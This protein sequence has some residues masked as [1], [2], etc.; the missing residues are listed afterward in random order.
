ML[1]VLGR[2]EDINQLITS[3][4]RLLK[5]TL[6]V[7]EEMLTIEE[8][9]QNVKHY[10]NI[11]NIVHLDE[12]E[13]EI[14]CEDRLKNMMIPKLL[15]QPIIENSILHGFSYGDE[16]KRKRI[17]ITVEENPS[18]QL[19]VTILDNGCG[20]SR[21]ILTNVKKSRRSHIRGI[22][23]KNVEERIH[24]LFGEEYG[25]EVES[26]LHK[27]TRVVVYIPMIDK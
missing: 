2:N 12:L 6:D 24:I 14:Q 22:G 1:S 21:E 8:E 23:L 10:F 13:L 25:V 27:G 3:L 20:I 15:L 7:S 26:E 5:G 9:L 16:K 11:E 17:E 18:G 19:C 4:V